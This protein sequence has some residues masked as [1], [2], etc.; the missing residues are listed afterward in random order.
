MCVGLP[1]VLASFGYRSMILCD[2]RSLRLL[3]HVNFLLCRRGTLLPFV[4]H[5][6]L[7]CRTSTIAAVHPQWFITTASRLLPLFIVICSLSSMASENFM[8]NLWPSWPDHISPGN[9]D[10]I[11]SSCRFSIFC[12]PVG[13]RLIVVL[14]MAVECR[15]YYIRAFVNNFLTYERRIGHRPLSVR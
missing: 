5:G 1:I 3:S 14:L 4:K 2:Q 7:V 13:I 12:S 10:I 15:A 6:H 8:L 9:M 11:L